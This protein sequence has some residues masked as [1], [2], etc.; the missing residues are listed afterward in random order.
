MTYVYLAV[1]SDGTLAKVG[2]SD[3]PRSRLLALRCEVKKLFGDIGKLEFAW[4]ASF[5]YRRRAL[6]VENNLLLQYRHANLRGEYFSCPSTLIERVKQIEESLPLAQFNT[7]TR[8][9][10]PKRKTKAGGVDWDLVR[11]FPTLKQQRLQSK[12]YRD[13]T[14]PTG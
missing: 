6:I 4:I 7:P 3:S 8:K 2:V 5:L 11:K 1:S 9:E 14:F 13:A 12:E 10:S